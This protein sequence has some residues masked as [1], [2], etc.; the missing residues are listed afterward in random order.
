MFRRAVG[1]LALCAA[2]LAPACGDGRSS[3]ANANPDADEVRI[4]AAA[5]LS[6]V[7]ES[8]ARQFEAE[9][10]CRVA[11]SLGASN[12]LAQQLHEGAAPGVFISAST[13]WVDKLEGWGI[14]EPGSRVDLAGNALVV[15]VPRDATIRPANLRDL[16]DARYPRLAL[17]DPAAVPAGKYAKAALEK[18]GVFGDVRSRIVA[19]QDV[20]TAL[21][22]VERGEAPVGI[23]YATD[24]ATSDKVDVAF[25]VP[26]ELHPRI[27][28]PMVLVKGAGPRARELHALLQTPEAWAAFEEAGFVKP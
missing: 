25:R 1:L 28:Y 4:Y 5:S 17:A 16:A 11:A 20:R 18:A 7:V 27:V 23:V 19:A 6:D 22:Y 10:S 14:V 3:A 13:E 24:A 26:S 8:V 15:V 2:G 21:A 9:S 12:T